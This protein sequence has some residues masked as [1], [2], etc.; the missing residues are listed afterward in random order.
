MKQPGQKLQRLFLRLF[1]ELE[2]DTILHLFEKGVERH[3]QTG[4]FLFHQGDDQHTMYIVLQGRL[5]AI[6]EKNGESKILGDIGAG[7]TVG[8]MAFFTDEPRMA[9]VVALRNTQ[10]LEFSPGQY[11]EITNS[12]PAFT[13]SLFNLVIRRIRRNAFEQNKSTPPRN[14]V[15]V[16]LQQSSTM[17]QLKASVSWEFEKRSGPFRLY[18]KA[19]I[20]NG[21][22]N[23]LFESV[24]EHEGINLFFCDPSDPEWAKQCVIYGDLI[25]VATDFSAKPDITELEE[26][27]GI[28]HQEIHY[29]NVFL[30]CIHESTK[31]L[32][33]NT[34]SWL[35]NRPV[36]LHVHLRT[37]HPQDI[38]RLY[39]II[40]QKAV[41][42]VLGGGGARGFAH[43]GVVRALQEAGIPIDFLGGTSAGALY[44]IGMAFA[45]FDFD[46]IHSLNEEAVRRKLT[47]GDLTLPMISLMTGKKFKGYLKRMFGE[48]RMEDLWINTYCLSTNLSRATPHVHRTGLVWKQVYASMAIPGV[49][50]PV[51]IDGCLHV[52]G[53]VM[54]NLPVE[55]MYGY[56][57]DTLIAV[58]LDRMEIRELTL[59]E[60]PSP[61]KLLWDQLVRRKKHH[62]PGITSLL[63]N[64]LIIN[65]R[66]KESTLKDSV[67]HYI[68]LDLKGVKMLE[69][70]NWRPIAQ[71]G[72]EQ[73]KTYL[74]NTEWARQ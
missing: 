35:E 27:L 17:E 60:I 47:S 22:M 39:R 59:N 15:F 28:Y 44:G 32:S 64:S 25:V 23:L 8:E 37:G 30:L 46:R 3:L 48:C 43:I 31:S 63:T 29:K 11:L 21:D 62:L 26:Y 55:Y 74:E 71:K 34:A 12:H 20:P 69:D 70:T 65:S 49:F 73:M 53:G 45:D 67:T 57:V 50:P 41:G 36:D 61:W 5:R 10:V 2:T 33:E 16:A 18:D 14:V 56:P 40:R 19:S 52:D 54:D 38:A 1:P 6:R 66:Q 42:L 7:E 4:E 9:S 13:H 72:Y 24:E 51:I 58:S 68:K